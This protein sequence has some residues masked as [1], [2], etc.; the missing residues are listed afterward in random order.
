MD[1]T[2]K[3]VQFIIGDKQWKTAPGEV[4]YVLVGRETIDTFQNK[5]LTHSSNR[6]NATSITV[7]GVSSPIL[8]TAMDGDTIVYDEN[9]QTLN[10]TT[11][12][13][14]SPDRLTVDGADRVI[15][16]GIS[17]NQVMTWN[18]TNLV[19]TGY[20]P[21]DNLVV[22]GVTIPIVGTVANGNVLQYNG[23]QFVFTAPSGSN[24]IV[25]CATTQSIETY[26]NVTSAVFSLTGGNNSR[27][28]LTVVATALTFDGVL[29]DLNMRVLIKNSTTGTWNH[30]YY[31]ESIVGAGPSYTYTFQL[32]LDAYAIAIM[33]IISV[34]DGYLNKGAQFVITSVPNVNA[35]IVFG[36]SNIITGT[37]IGPTGSITTNTYVGEDS[38]MNNA[39]VYDMTC[40]GYA[41]GGCDSP[42]V[43]N[44]GYQS[45]MI[46]TRAG[47][48]ATGIQCVY[49]GTDAGR[50]SIK[51]TGAFPSDYNIGIGFKACSGNNF[52]SYNIV[53]SNTNNVLMPGATKTV[54]I[55]SNCTYTTGARHTDV[56]TIGTTCNIA[57]GSTDCTFVGT[58]SSWGLSTNTVAIGSYMNVT[59]GTT[60]SVS[61]GSFSYARTNC[62]SI[63]INAA[64]DASG[65]AIGNTA[66]SNGGIAIGTNS[67]ATGGIAIGELASANAVTSTAVGW[68][69][70]ANVT[71]AAANNTGL[72]HN[73][74][75]T[76]TT[77]TGCTLIGAGA[78][79]NSATAVDRIAIG[80]AISNTVDSSVV[81]GNNSIP[82]ITANATGCTAQAY[83]QITPAV[84]KASAGTYTITAA[85]M[86]PSSV[87]VSSSQAGP[88][89]W[90]TAT[91]AL[92]IARLPTPTVGAS[93]L[94][95][96]RNESAFTI[97][98]AAGTSVT[99]GSGVYS[100]ATLTCVTFK[101]TLTS[102]STI[103]LQR[104]MSTGI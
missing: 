40:V 39:V 83:Y 89:T 12:A 34:S 52:G 43:S 3:T 44:T 15:T 69:A 45:V 31:C 96:L 70:Y 71:G 30:I 63:G 37:P 92:I 21:N 47:F 2:E 80:R 66:V 35:A 53:L 48:N 51:Q 56:I 84:T 61:I 4:Q 95:Y 36:K 77:G 26:P 73:V 64:S 57:G 19:F 8:G 18:G 38:G 55:L 24:R 94:F 82:Y 98:I 54:Q 101:V 102:A 46:G 50:A 72:G 91:A 5:D 17:A 87:I 67:K 7:N 88:E 14:G 60:D 79:V 85:E 25:R 22:N 9:T 13:S 81:I 104:V 62:V 97:T 23:S 65:V 90:T 49:M 20:A 74:G 58:N 16:G 78:N 42:A 1:Y 41:A 11:P 29:V 86:Q 99:L 76:L 75:I 6:V 93:Y 28:R 68:S 100:V 32:A 27:R 33:D 10:W 59:D 103:T